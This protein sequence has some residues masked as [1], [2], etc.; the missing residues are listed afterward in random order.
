MGNRV[1]GMPIRR[2]DLIIK[3]AE[4]SGEL[5]LPIVRRTSGFK[6]ELWPVYGNPIL[7]WV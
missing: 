3:M 5:H 6:A 2:M 7:P 4:R 1:T